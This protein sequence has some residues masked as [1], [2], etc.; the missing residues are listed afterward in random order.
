MNITDVTAEIAP[1]RIAVSYSWTTQEMP[2]GTQ[3]LG[4][5][6]LY[7]VKNEAG[8]PLFSSPRF[9]DCLDWVRALKRRPL[10]G[11]EQFQDEDR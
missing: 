8:E 7:T 9:E 10:G 11:I 2:D 6:P 3:Y 1:Y 4:D 5:W